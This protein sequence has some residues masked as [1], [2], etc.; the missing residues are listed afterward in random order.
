MAKEKNLWLLLRE[1]LPNIHLQR[2]ETGMTGAGI[3]D[4]NGCGKGKE[5]WIELK[6]IHSGNKLTL[7]PMQISWLAK[8]ASYGGQVFVMARKNNEI[9]LFHIDSLTGIKDLVKGGY[10]SNA[11]LTLAIPYNWEALATA[12]LS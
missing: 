6:E 7:R 9:K 5:F 11:L 8:R 10:S 4:V 3:P 12:L 1:N 2:I